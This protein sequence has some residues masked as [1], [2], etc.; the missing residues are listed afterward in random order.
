MGTLDDSFNEA[1]YLKEHMDHLHSE[2]RDDCRLCQAMVM[3]PHDEISLKRHKEEDSLHTAGN[4][5]CPGCE[6]LR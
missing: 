3:T 6:S 5:A 2:F 1:A 4:Y